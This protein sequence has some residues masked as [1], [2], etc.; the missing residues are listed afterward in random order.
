MLVGIDIGGTKVALAVGDAGGTVIARERRPTESTSRAADDVTRIAEDVRRLL[1]KAGV[2]IQDVDAIGVSVPGPIDL[3]KG[4]VMHPPNIPSWGE[5]PIGAW[6]T[7]Q[8]GRPVYIENDANA[9]ALAE[10]HF[11]AG[12]GLS[13][14]VY[15]T[16]STGVGGGLIL[17]GA[18]HRGRDGTAGELGHV[19]VEWEGE[20]C[21]CGLRGCLEAYVG[22][23]AWTHRLRAQ[24]PEGG[25]VVSLA[26]AKSDVRPEHVV[27]AAREGDPYAL[28]EM[29]RYND[30]LSRAIAQ[31]VFTLAPEVVILGTIPTAAGE[32]LCL[33]PIREKVAVQVWP[34]QAPY[35]R[36]VPA[37]LGE[38]LP[39]CA[40]L[41]VALAGR[42]AP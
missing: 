16:M 11:G 31:L 24:A 29:D 37:A 28:A 14:V 38:D 41:S 20:R 10:W 15:L 23:A 17:G 4:I 42:D 30:Y 39:Y 21:A 9:A 12:Q 5:V 2:A 40:G 3:S 19:L 6:L 34:H 33:Q 35:M 7:E 22:G 1:A 32:D 27:E 25:R 18:L 13:D 8:L 26:G 36:I